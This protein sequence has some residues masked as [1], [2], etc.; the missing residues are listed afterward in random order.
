MPPRPP[1]PPG[2][3]DPEK[4]LR[5]IERLEGEVAT[6]R[7]A[8]R[9]PIA[10]VGMS[11]RFPGADGPDA[12]W[13]HL[14]RGEETTG[15]VPRDRWNVD[16]LYSA[17]PDTPGKM[18]TRYGGFLDHVDR[19]DAAFFGIA[20][21]EAMVMDPQQRLLL[22]LSW[23]AL[24]DAGLSPDALYGSPTGVFV[25]V[26]ASDYCR[27]AL[28]NVDNITAYLGTGNATS[29]AA[30]RIAYTF[31]FSGPCMSLDT[32]CSSA[33]VAVHYAGDSLRRGE[34]RVAL[35]A[36]VNL[37]LAP[38]ITVAFSRARMM[39]PDGRCKT[40]DERADGYVRSEG[41]AVLVLKTLSAA[42]A[43]GD[44]ILAV[45]RGTAINQDGA[46]GGLTVPSGPSQS[47][48]VRQ[49]LARAGVT[50]NDIDYLEAHGTGTALGDP[51][52]VG[53]L[54]E[55]FA[56]GR[57]ADRPL[58][59]GSVKTLVGHLEVAA[60][61][62]GLIKVILALQHE[63]VPGYPQLQ[64]LSSRIPWHELPFAVPRQPVPWPRGPRPRLAGVSAFGFS[65]TNAHVVVEEPPRPGDRD[66]GADA[67][68]AHV[69]CLSART[70][71][72]LGALARRYA[73][74]LGRHPGATLDEIAWT[75]NT[76]RA[77]LSQRLAVVADAPAALQGQLAA[78]A[79]T[80]IAA[81]KTVQLGT[82]PALDGQ[83]A[84]LFT[85]Q[86]SPYAGMGKELHDRHPVFRQAIT[87]CED[88]LAAH[89]DLP[90]RELL[91]GEH[92]A[93]L[94]QT[95]YTQP[96]LFALEIALANLWQAWG[97]RPAYV[98]GHSVGEL[99][100]A[101]VAGVF[102]LA[103][104]C[105][106]VAARGR[107]MQEL[108]DDGAMAVVL[109]GR[110]VARAVVEAVRQRRGDRL[111]L[112]GFNA[113]DQTVISGDRAA[114]LEACERLAVEHQIA[115]RGLLDV[116]HAFHS[117]LMR[118][119][120]DQLRAVAETV[121]YHRPTIDVVSNVTGTVA[122]AA[123]ATAAYWVDHVLAPVDFMAG[124]RALDAGGVTG[125]L[126][127][128]PSATLIGLASAC[129][130]PGRFVTCASLRPKVAP[131]SQMLEALATLFVHG[132]AVD[133]RKAGRCDQ[134]PP[135]RRGLP[136]YPFQRQRYW[137][138]GPD[139]S[140]GPAGAAGSL[141]PPDQ[142]G[143][144]HPLLG[145]RLRSA[146]LP[147]G[148]LSYE[149]ALSPDRPA[150]LRH[151][152]VYDKVVV[153]AAAYVELALAGVRREWAHAAVALRN[154]AVQ[155]ALVLTP[156][157]ETVVQT[158]LA[159]AGGNRYRVKIWS[160]AASAAAAWQ[161]HATG[162]LEV[163]EA[164]DASPPGDAPDVHERF[165]ERGEPL[166]L[167][168]FYERYATLGLRY[169]GE[170]RSVVELRRLAGD[171]ARP[172]EILAR[173]EPPGVSSGD[174]EGYVLH[175]AL[176]DGCFQA[177][178]AMVEAHAGVVY[179]PV[180]IEA[181]R[182]LRAA[183]Q[184]SQPSQAPG[185]LW[186]HAVLRHAP[187]P[188]DPRVIADLRLLDDDGRLIGVVEG[189]LAVPAD[190]RAL[191][192]ATATWK[193]KLYT[194]GWTPQR[195][196]EAPAAAPGEA[197]R[198]WL[199]L[200]DR[201]GTGAALAAVLEAHG[202]PCA[203]LGEADVDPLDKAAWARALADL[204]NAS[205]R[206][207]TGVV[208][209][210]ALD[211]SPDHARDQAPIDGLSA[212]EPSLAR[213]CGSTLALVQALMATPGQRLPRLWLVTR[214]AQAVTDG[215]PVTAAA[216]ALW[217]LGRTIALEHP[218]LGCTCVDIDDDDG[219]AIAAELLRPDGELQVALRGGKRHVARL[220]RQSAQARHQLA[221]PGE[222][223]RLR[224]KAYGSLD[225]LTLVSAE[226][227]AP[228]AGEVE[229]E[230]GASAINFKDVLHCL[231]ML[232]EFS[233]AAGIHRAVDQPLGFECAGVVARTGTGV[234]GLAAGDEVFAMAPSALASHVTIDHRLVHRK[235]ANLTLA[236]AAS[237]P[238][239]FMTA[240]YSLEK[241]ARLRE[242][243][244]VLIHAC[245]GGVGQAAIQIARARG[246]T[247]YG[248]A[249]PAKWS[250]VKQH[251]VAHV[252]SSRTL[253]FT[254]EILRLT[255]GRGV[256]VVL[257]SL[258]GPFIARSADALARGGRFVEIGKIGIW[259]PAEMAA[260]RPDVQYF[261]FDLGDV[262]GDGALQAELLAEAVRGLE[263]GHV[264][265]LPVKTFSIQDAEA[266]FRYL[267]QAR[268]IGK[269]VLTLPA[270]AQ[271]SRQSVVRSDRSYWITGGLGALGLSVARSLVASGARQLVLSGRSE[272]EAGALEAIASLRAAGAEVVLERLDVADAGQVA[273]VVQRITGPGDDHAPGLLPLGGIVHA[274]GV[275]DDGVIV[276]QTWP[277]FAGVLAPKAIGA[278]HLHVATRPLALDFFV[279]FS[280]IA[281]MLG[282]PGQANYA[283]ANAFLDGLAALRRSQGLP[284]TCIAWG[285]WAAGGMAERARAANR[286]RAASV[287]LGRM[288]V[289]DNLEVFE[290]LLN[291]A[292]VTV[293]VAD[294]DFPKYLKTVTSPG[295]ARFY[296]LVDQGAA[297]GEPAEVGALLARLTKEPD[298]RRLSVLIDFLRRQVASVVG[299]ASP[300]AI[301]VTQRLLDVGFD[302]LM[303]VELKNRVESS[304]GATLSPTIL[305]DHP[306]LAQ[307]ARHLLADVLHLRTASDAAPAPGGAPPPSEAPPPGEPAT[308]AAV[309]LAT[310]RESFLA[311][312]DGAKLC[313]C[314]WGPAETADAP[315]AICVH[316]VLDQAA[317]W[318]EVAVGLALRGYR[319]MALDLR[320]HGRSAHHPANVAITVLDFLLDL[321]TLAAEAK[322]PF[323]LIGHSMG[324]TVAALFASAHPERVA[325]LIL[326]EPVMP[327]LRGQLSALELL[328]NELRYLT[329]PPAHA[330]YPD[331][332]T[333][334][335][336]LTLSHGG[337]SATRS[338]RLAQRI[339][340]PYEG[341]LRWVWDARLRNP[342]G[343]DL[344][345]SREHYLALFGALG[346]ASTRI[347]GTTSQFLGTPVLLDP[348][349]VLPRSRSV[350]IAGGHNLHTDAA[351][352]LLAE[353]LR[354]W[355][356][357]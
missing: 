39:A 256:D 355:N 59:L 135:V 221:I 213:S 171:A 96:V 212:V 17:N 277:R 308:G 125:L 327:H 335:R 164:G 98:M 344:C 80:R 2:A 220:Q 126:E 254:D 67:Q 119:I 172:A 79:E 250:H 144:R 241:L 296:A 349:A 83:L 165:A 336:M 231:G 299:L 120:L 346:V 294:V 150:Y 37:I 34:C 64:E 176:L 244:T 186:A 227:R 147:S 285:P 183:S 94:P 132:F 353:M 301:E 198:R 76:G 253:D 85:G 27:M 95:R 23:E 282:A 237:I 228:A 196:P 9:E 91:W 255:G 15:E 116:S 328:K 226:R 131:W 210:R 347:Y 130:D 74:W 230:V 298:D 305:F 343:I 258:T 329:E 265:P 162:E 16:A 73:D 109:T 219:A 88:L 82:A 114:V 273:R 103:D 5:I 356:L 206:P 175:P 72:A 283:A 248:T 106:L 223:Y 115:N 357:A 134:P 218:S 195:L 52:E 275:L 236:Q 330:T 69:V 97:V 291:G 215:E 181:V 208:H 148:D 300:D 332:P 289:G 200:G 249:S 143:D 261:S 188:A 157:V 123:M 334:A 307:L 145:R 77:R 117:P 325:H 280:S 112:A 320:G 4:V 338:M 340:E 312:S 89:L 13:S 10:V 247:I 197:G 321:T 337:L 331:L 191:A 214:G 207:L 58:L 75:A 317:I 138:H 22:E 168:A 318:D 139:G 238:A 242:G 303:A 26:C 44:R 245:A 211:D 121:T 87:R 48:L 124:V 260:Y 243:D 217:G 315:L 42:R 129:A 136:A 319:V 142:A 35:A 1:T 323:V 90:L 339:T 310:M 201:G 111:A 350:R 170:F 203:L 302:S 348:D 43:D 61:M 216:A 290:H 41:A 179:L 166:D 104:G 108:R 263:A 163:T 268:N 7:G 189:L 140:M 257:N 322:R 78:F 316:G 333:A 68:P 127:V 30:G 118:P 272:P 169:G 146:A 40:F 161:L 21:R 199:V 8:Q 28:Q 204:A 11:C 6:L 31:G 156:D 288:S 235:P 62:A 251:G 14:Y 54:A 159:D 232:A 122:N 309:P 271:A 71:D 187:S 151:H 252:M 113:P 246:A 297:R 65:G 190:R 240:I 93:L 141:Q 47:A 293:A 149:T 20:P 284:A 38:E 274:A 60:G 167:D 55:V 269:I 70:P 177:V 193:D 33:L 351:A 352:M 50:P 185:G 86:G 233:E 29:V 278:F 326:V 49:A 84:L 209:L 53:A 324:A 180:G 107:L 192:Y 313:I 182:P 100:A 304:L 259:S 279:M 287:G 264:A 276:K 110:D 229:I 184:L 56:R 174:A 46:S 314:A 306:T 292:P 158:H 173:I 270:L 18:S 311:A 341:G 137:I 101:C 262:E 205:D 194:L 152:R 286:A 178:G 354:G 154:V 57:P 36:S 99:A 128:G 295:V 224:T 342:L 63:A 153:P 155:A 25:G 345:F 239:A 81:G 51:I 24:E 267:A 12:F 133:F 234:T 105:K 3:P 160:A 222:S 202:E 266:G 281:G 92:T 32:A 45:I 66:V 19:F 102:D 225:H